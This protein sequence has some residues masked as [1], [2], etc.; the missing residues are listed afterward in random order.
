MC[1]RCGVAA[2]A[3]ALSCLPLRAAS[4]GPSFRG[5]VFGRYPGRTWDF[6]D[7]P[8]QRGAH[9]RFY[10]QF[11]SLPCPQYQPIAVSTW[12]TLPGGVYSVHVS[13]PGAKPEHHLAWLSEDRASVQFRATRALPAR[14]L[15]LPSEARLSQD[16]RHEVLEAIVPLPEDGDPTNAT[17]R[18]ASHGLEVL[19]PK[20]VLVSVASR[21]E[22]VTSASE[23]GVRNS[24]PQPATLVTTDGIE[25]T[26][27]EIQEPEKDADA[28]EGWW[29]RR[30]VFHEYGE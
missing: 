10:N 8:Y 9:D 4:V 15:C 19:I 30:G 3:V 7:G 18:R 23:V 6:D 17:V 22:G 2:I 11:E 25:I 5:H 1:R 26:D 14:G 13:L 20:R 24:S 16:G 29:D 28:A 12:E 21:T 27:E